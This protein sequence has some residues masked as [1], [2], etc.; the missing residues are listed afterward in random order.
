MNKLLFVLCVI[1]LFSMLFADVG[2]EVS[3]LFTMDTAEPV[4][5]VLYPDGG[6]TLLANQETIVSWTASDGHLTGSTI[7][8]KFSPDN[9]SYWQTLSGSESNDGSYLW[10]VTN[11]STTEALIKIMATDDFGNFADDISAS[12]FNIEF[13][14][15]YGVSTIFGMDTVDPTLDLTSPDGGEEWY[16]DDYHDILWS[17][18]DN[19]FPV[20]PINIQFSA[21]GDNYTTVS[22]FEDNDGVYNWQI[23]AIQTENGRVKILVADTFGNSVEDFSA[24][25]FTISYVPPAA[26]TNVTV[27]TSNEIDAIITWAEVD[28]TIYGTNIDVDGYIVLYNETPYEEDNYYYFLG[29]T[30]NLT[31]TH[32]RVAEFRDQMFYKVVAYKDYRGNIS[33]YLASLSKKS[34][35]KMDSRFHGKDNVVT[36]LSLKDNLKEVNF[37]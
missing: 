14:S 19:H 34:N 4:V 32:Q 37:K 5:D 11:V 24:S 20:T 18:S 9:G 8:V 33:R 17:A 13:E 28:T 23:P 29:A 1:S 31:L 21:T 22:E 36:W 27:D 15:S 7:T 30:S 2:E 35:T 6:E 12:V 10:S 26:P 16:I 25:V 3:A